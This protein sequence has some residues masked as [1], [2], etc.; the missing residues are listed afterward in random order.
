MADVI[1][2]EATK[3]ADRKI[4]LQDHHA[5]KEKRKKAVRLEMTE[6]HVRS[7]PTKVHDPNVKTASNAHIKVL[8]EKVMLPEAIVL[9]KN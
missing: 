6:A 8:R 5:R 1:A 4:A 7:D 9:P 2:E 3:T